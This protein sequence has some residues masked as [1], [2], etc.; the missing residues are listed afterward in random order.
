[1]VLAPGA[2][3]EVAGAYKAVFERDVAAYRLRLMQYMAVRDGSHESSLPFACMHAR[4][5]L[6]QGAR[7][8]MWSGC[9]HPW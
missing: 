2:A 5:G 9:V 1:M 8:I 6:M 4:V 7:A 3:D